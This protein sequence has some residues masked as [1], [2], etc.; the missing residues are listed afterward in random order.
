MKIANKIFLDRVRSP[1]ETQVVILKSRDILTQVARDFRDSII[2]ICEV[3][4]EFKRCTGS[5]RVSFHS[6][7]T[8]FV[9]ESNLNY[10]LCGVRA[11]LVYHQ[12]IDRDSEEYAQLLLPMVVNA[13]IGSGWSIEDVIKRIVDLSDYN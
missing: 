10:S 8:L 9:L 12:G 11:G 1:E 3:T 5:T 6:S 2:S 13:A 4:P 7:S